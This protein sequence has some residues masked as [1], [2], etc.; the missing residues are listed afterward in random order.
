MSPACSPVISVARVFVPCR[1][2]NIDS[3]KPEMFRPN[4]VCVWTASFGSSLSEIQNYTRFHA[5]TF[6]LQRGAKITGHTSLK[7]T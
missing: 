7:W 2:E 4:M 3:S 6:C 5:A 1:R